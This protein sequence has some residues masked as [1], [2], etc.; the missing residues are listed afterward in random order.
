V[1]ELLLDFLLPETDRG[2]L[3]QWIVIGPV[4]IVALVVSRSWRREHRVFVFGLVLVNF[5]WFAVRT[6]H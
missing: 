5:A 3:I 1:V 2:V 6:A 4:W